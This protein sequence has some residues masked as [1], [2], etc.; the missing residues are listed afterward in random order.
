MGEH[1]LVSRALKGVFN[2]R[3]PLPQYS[4]F[5]D[6]SVVLQHIIQLGHNYSLSLHQLMLLTVMLLALLDLQNQLIFLG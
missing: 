4:T 6:V 2:T 1:P 3:S 5:W